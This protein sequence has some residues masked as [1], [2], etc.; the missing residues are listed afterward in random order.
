MSSLRR[1]RLSSELW[2]VRICLPWKYARVLFWIQF[3]YQ[4]AP[5]IYSSFSCWLS[6]K[7]CKRDGHNAMTQ[8]IH[9]RNVLCKK[10]RLSCDRL[11]KP[12]SP[13][14]MHYAKIQIKRRFCYCYECENQKCLQQHDALLIH[15]LHDRFDFHSFGGIWQ[16]L[17][18]I[19]PPTGCCRDRI[20][21]NCHQWKIRRPVGLKFVSIECASRPKYYCLESHHSW[22][23][24]H[25]ASRTYPC[26]RLNRPFE[27][28]TFFFL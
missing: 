22:N 3:L 14:N 23:R 18:R 13:V 9:M 5:E 26:S 7:R 19:R 25:D 16:K 21:I 11:S 27:N 6:N 28:K 1:L 17:L 12:A 10:T 4:P 15:R 24:A 20:V 8:Q 2:V